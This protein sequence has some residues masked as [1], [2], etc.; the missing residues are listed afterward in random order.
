M[1]Q[2]RGSLTRDDGATTRDGGSV[3]R[4]G[5][6]SRDGGA[7]TRQLGGAEG[8]IR[9]APTAEVARARQQLLDARRSLGMEL[10]G[11]TTSTQ[12][13]LDIPAKVRRDPVKA[14][15]VAGGIGFFVL[16]GPRRVMRA[17]TSRLPRRRDP[18][19]GLLPEEIER[20]LRDSG[21]AKDPRVR[22]AIERDFADYLATKGRF[23][24]QHGPQASLWRTYDALIG[25]LGTV[26]A[27]RLVERLFA[28][29]GGRSDPDSVVDGVPARP[30]TGQDAAAKG[31]GRAGR[32]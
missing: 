8:P 28:A 9:P 16:G 7:V 10:D 12:A 11:L 20:V 23:E 1:T 5:A 2:E 29:D 25:P 21:V 19:R 4:D 22:E 3:A 17:V 6:G 15:A 31:S 13:A 18:Y 26:A 24:Q 32:R 30:R 14:A 27:R